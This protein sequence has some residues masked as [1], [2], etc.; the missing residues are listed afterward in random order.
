LLPSFNS[1]I[2]PPPAD[3]V[4]SAQALT[5]YVPMDVKVYEGEVAVFDVFEVKVAIDLGARSLTMPPPFAAVA[6]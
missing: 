4:L 6:T 3:E 2:I 1:S 5:E